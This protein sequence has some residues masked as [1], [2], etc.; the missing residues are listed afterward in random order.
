MA[1]CRDGR[2]LRGCIGR[3][4]SLPILLDGAH[5]AHASFFGKIVFPSHG[6]FLHSFLCKASRPE[7]DQALDSMASYSD[8]GLDT[9]ASYLDWALDLMASYSYRALD[10]M[11]SYSDRG[12]D[13][14]ALYSDQALD[15]MASYSDRAL[16]L[17]A[18]YFFSARSA[19][20]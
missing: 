18:S 7:S 4:S 14:M 13:T 3:R 8:R 11:A 9:M 16:D 10:S 6:H 20:A 5:D 17:M 2:S 12:L 19:R 1:C 15:L